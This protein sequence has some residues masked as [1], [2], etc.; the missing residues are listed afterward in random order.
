MQPIVQTVA[1]FSAPSSPTVELGL[2]CSNEC[3]EQGQARQKM[4][5]Y[6]YNVLADFFK[7]QGLMTQDS[8]SFFYFHILTLQENSELLLQTSYFIM[9]SVGM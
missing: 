7:Y 5:E 2:L 9:S 6:D 8:Y 4:N 3:K 1:F